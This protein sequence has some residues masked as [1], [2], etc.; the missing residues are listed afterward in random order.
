MGDAI[1]NYVQISRG[2]DTRPLTLGLRRRRTPYG[3]VHDGQSCPDIWA[4]LPFSTLVPAS[5]QSHDGITAAS[6]IVPL[7]TGPERVVYGRG[8]PPPLASRG[9]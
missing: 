9:A 7:P 5:P 1:P 3:W 4:R 8:V 2:L 6:R